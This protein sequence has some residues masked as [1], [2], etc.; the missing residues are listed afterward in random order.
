ML[1]VLTAALD[2]GFAPARIGAKN[3]AYAAT[4]AL[5]ARAQVAGAV[6]DPASPHALRRCVGN[7]TSDALL[8]ASIEDEELLLGGASD[9]AA[10]RDAFERAARAGK[11]CSIDAAAWLASPA[12]STLRLVH[13]PDWPG[14]DDQERVARPGGG[15]PWYD[16]SGEEYMARAIAPEA[17]AAALRA[18][19]GSALQRG[20]AV[21]DDDAF[22]FD[23]SAGASSSHN[24]SRT[25]AAAAAAPD[26]LLAREVA[27][28]RSHRPR[29][30]FVPTADDE[31]CTSRGTP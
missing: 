19:A 11:F 16:V 14:A 17:V 28:L 2:A 6:L 1:D 21:D 3:D 18:M 12:A 22:D 15:H 31:G 26:E 4:E 30:A 29:T 9:A 7:V 5:F 25:T 23:E 27:R 8:R 10:L 24:T 13:T 20:H